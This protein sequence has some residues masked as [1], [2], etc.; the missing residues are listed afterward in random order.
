MAG[1]ARDTQGCI[2]GHRRLAHG[3]LCSRWLCRVTSGSPEY[4]GT[5]QTPRRCDAGPAA[6][7]SMP[8]ALSVGSRSIT[9][10]HPAWLHFKSNRPHALSRHT[11]AQLHI[12]LQPILTSTQNTCTHTLGLRRRHTHIGRTHRGG[13]CAAEEALPSFA[14]RSHQDEVCPRG[15]LRQVTLAAAG[16]GDGATLRRNHRCG[17]RG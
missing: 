12:L 15:R 2:S 1:H 7:R 11:H 3:T 14:G 17:T 13:S 9:H 16:G 4:S 5:R 10:F 6:I 8:C